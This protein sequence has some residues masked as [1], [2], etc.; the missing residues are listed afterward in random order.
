MYFV[1]CD[2]AIGEEFEHMACLHEE[3]ESGF[4]ARRDCRG[5]KTNIQQHRKDDWNARLWHSHTHPFAREASPEDSWE[6]SL[7]PALLPL[8]CVRHTFHTNLRISLDWHI[9]PLCSDSLMLP[10][11][12][13]Q[14]GFIPTKVA[15]LS[16][17]VEGGKRVLVLKLQTPLGCNF[18]DWF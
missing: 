5:T 9:S 2:V 4:W 12:R 3:S 10:M 13:L 18:C 7:F 8:S 17:F 1:T 15:V 6:T 16:Q 11:S 14:S